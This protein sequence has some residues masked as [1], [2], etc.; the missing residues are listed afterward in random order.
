MG[1]DNRPFRGC[2]VPIFTQAFV[3]QA[4]T[5]VTIRNN[6]FLYNMTKVHDDNKVIGVAMVPNSSQNTQ[7]CFHSYCESV[8]KNVFSFTGVS[9]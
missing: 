3:K 6:V 5:L 8:P 4:V 9:V 7:P 1:A 2:L